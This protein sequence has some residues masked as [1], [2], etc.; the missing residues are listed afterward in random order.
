[1]NKLFD[2]I[3]KKGYVYKITSKNTTDI[4]IGSCIIDVKERLNKH[5]HMNNYYKK[6]NT[7]YCNSFKI[8]EHGDVNITIIDEYDNINLKDLRIIEGK[9]IRD[10][11]K[12]C[13]NR[14]VNGRNRREYE[15]DNNDK[16]KNYK[17]LYYEKNKERI[18]LYR[19]KNKEKIKQYNYARY[20][21]METIS[22]I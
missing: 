9:Y 18:K 4:Y 16:I 19:E 2:K 6:H 11:L 12:N 7:H 1:M 20:H 3:Y 14:I 13:V 22:Q 15:D 8:L 5:K 10:N 21:N 17:K